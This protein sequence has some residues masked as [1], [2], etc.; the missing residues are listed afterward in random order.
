MNTTPVRVIGK[1]GQ[2][3]VVEAHG[4][5]AGEEDTATADDLTHIELEHSRRLQRDHDNV[6]PCGNPLTLTVSFQ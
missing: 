1:C 6:C 2:N 4:E 3:V 5:F